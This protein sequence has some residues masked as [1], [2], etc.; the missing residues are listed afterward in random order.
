LRFVFGVRLQPRDI[1]HAF[2]HV[3][4]LLLQAV[5]RCKRN[6]EL[7]ESFTRDYAESATDERALELVHLYE[8]P[9]YG[10]Q[11]IA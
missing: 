2:E 6:E 7:L 10:W 5:E 3:P 4:A 1:S 11:I 8:G 9:V